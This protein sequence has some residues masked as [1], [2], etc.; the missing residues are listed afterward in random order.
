MFYLPR[1]VCPLRWYNH[2][3]KLSV[4]KALYGRRAAQHPEAQGKCICN[5]FVPAHALN[6]DANICALL[7]KWASA[8]LGFLSW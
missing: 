1:P 8:I 2:A 5:A 7:N 4:F 6:I 3:F